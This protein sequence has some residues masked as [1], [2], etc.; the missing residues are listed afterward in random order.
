MKK[1]LKAAI[2]KAVLPG[3][4][5]APDN[6]IKDIESNIQKINDPSA[7]NQFFDAF[8]IQF[9]YLDKL[10]T[11]GQALEQEQEDSLIGLLRWLIYQLRNW[12]LEN[13][14]NYCSLAAL[15]VIT[16][17]LDRD[18]IFWDVLEIQDLSS[19]FLCTL[20][21][22]ISTCSGNITP[23]GTVPVPVWEQEIVDRFLEADTN[24]DWLA[25]SEILPQFA[26]AFI[27]NII[28]NQSV[29]CLY[30]F[31]FEYLVE[32]VDS[33]EH[34]INAMQIAE[35]LNSLERLNLG[36]ASQNPYIKFCSVYR[37]AYNRYE[38]S[39][40]SDQ[41]IHALSQV[42]QKMTL[43]PSGWAQWMQVFNR[44]PI[45]FLR[46]QAALGLTL[47][48]SSGQ[49]LESYVDTIQ[50]SMYDSSSRKVVAECL[51]SFKN[52]ADLN[53]RK[54]MWTLA[55]Q[56]WKNWLDDSNENDNYHFQIG[57]SELD[58][59]LVAYALECMT[60]SE[61]EKEV[62]KIKERLFR[63]ENSW[64]KSISDFITHWNRLLELI[65]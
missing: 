3:N 5:L 30:K 17:Y 61:R 23:R 27:G 13:D 22:L 31:G 56:R 50:L 20:E 41:E 26:N 36:Q 54:H 19:D 24:K 60:Q 15:F 34:T 32:A 37:T 64:H 49:A 46:L 7:L 57:Y 53:R 44:Y 55:Y 59:A 29:I 10:H 39:L 58:Y 9:P 11:K 40:L 8:R 6:L 51:E 47:A 48:N 25:I 18:R 33:F 16:A 43:D 62:I 2:D 65:R 14:T 63:L 52:K 42:L 35:A 12:K 1:F 28:I 4:M 38:N 21:K 45:R